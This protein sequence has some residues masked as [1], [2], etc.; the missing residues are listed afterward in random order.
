M[1]GNVS[2]YGHPAL[3][4]PLTILGVE[5]RWFLLSLTLGLAIWNGANSLLAGLSI[6]VVLY[7][8]GW[9]AWQRDPNML[10]I[11]AAGSRSRARYDPAKH[12]RWHLDL[13]DDQ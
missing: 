1:R 9:F 11:V 2:W 3:S 12:P 10:A 8:A 13:I 4:R 7:L 5:R 6:F